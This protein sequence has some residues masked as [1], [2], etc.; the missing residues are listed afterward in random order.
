[1]AVTHDDRYFHVAERVLKMEEGRF[2]DL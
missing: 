1:V 2:V